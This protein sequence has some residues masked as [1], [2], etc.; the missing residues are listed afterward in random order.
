MTEAATDQGFVV[1]LEFPREYSTHP[2]SPFALEGAIRSPV[3]TKLWIDSLTDTTVPPGTMR[4]LLLNEPNAVTRL[5]NHVCEDPSRWD[6]ILAHN[7]RV[8]RQ[9]AN[10]V[11]FCYGTT[12]IRDY[13]FPPKAFGVSMLVSAQLVVNGHY[14]RRKLWDRRNEISTPRRFYISHRLKEIQPE[15]YV[16]EAKKEPMFDTQFHLAI[17]NSSTKN[18]FTEKIIDC[19]QTRTVPIYYGAT[20]IHRFFNPKGMFVFQND[21]EAVR[22]CNRLTPTTYAS[23]AAAVEDNYHRSFQ[24][25][26]FHKRLEHAIGELGSIW[27]RRRR[28]GLLARAWRNL[29]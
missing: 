10:S 7:P 26:D 19:F 16:L 27:P 13:T 8:L 9:C 23:M 20:N 4:V 15:G 1:N 24:W 12:W 25:L 28:F 3:P 18:Y 21:D 5:A 17:E 14:L 22:I 11:R 2:M 29:S 6:Y